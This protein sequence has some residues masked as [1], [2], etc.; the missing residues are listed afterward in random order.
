MNVRNKKTHKP[1]M[2]DKP[3]AAGSVGGQ[4]LWAVAAFL[5]G[6]LLV[7]SLLTPHDATSVFEGAAVPQ[8]LMG[9]ALAVVAPLA[10]ASLGL[11]VPFA[12]RSWLLLA[13]LLAW[14]VIATVLAG[15]GTNPRV[16][17]YGFWQ[18]IALGGGFF[19]AQALL[20][21]PRTRQTTLLILIVGCTAL[22]LQGLYQVAV[23][24]P[25]DRARYLA[26]P[27]GV[28]AEVPNLEAPP[29]SAARKRFEDRLLYSSEPYASFA[30]ANSL[31]VLLS[32][33]I[34]LLMG[35]SMA[36]LAGQPAL[37][38]PPRVPWIHFVPLAIA[39][40]AVLLTWFLTRSRV[41]YPA[42]IV[43]AAYWTLLQGPR[44]REL[45]RLLLWGVGLGSIG[46]LAGSVWLL[47]NDSLVLSEAPKSFSYR[48]EYWLASMAM[49]RDHWLMGIG[50]GNFQ[51]YYPIYKLPAA[52]EII[53]DP[54]NW[55]LDIL[56]SLS[57]P[58][59]VAICLWLA[60]QLWTGGPA[61]PA[62]AA[63][64]TLSSSSQS[65]S[66]SAL[67]QA[68]SQ[69]LLRGAM[70]GGSLCAVALSVLSGLNLWGAIISWF[71]AGLLI[72][73]ARP[74]LQTEPAQLAL[75]ARTA[76]V[77]MLACLL[78]SGSWQ[79]SGL[80]LPMILLLVI[81][82]KHY[83]Q[84]PSQTTATNPLPPTTAT[85]E[86]LVGWRR[87]WPAYLPLVG[88]FIFLIQC[89]RPTIGSWSHIQQA[90]SASSSKQQLALIDAAVQADPLDTEPL[91]M[92][93]QLLTQEAIHA[94]PALFEQMGS[95]AHASVEAWLARDCVKSLN[96]QWSGEHALQLA[97]TAQTLGLENEIYV[98]RAVGYYEQALARYPS[99]IGLR[100]QLAITFA[101][102]DQW[103]E[104]HRELQ[105]ALELD[106]QT[107]HLDKKLESQQ[108]WLPLLPAEAEAELALQKP[109]IPA[110][111]VILWL[112]KSISEHISP[113][114]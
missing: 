32:G 42:L 54:H 37:P 11:R 101:I 72:V 39:G 23:E 94:P 65:N 97:A 76:V 113:E 104:S 19:S 90:Q 88:L 107:P 41:A 102:A 16:A 93:A 68:T 95:Q 56:V 31:A 1:S 26:D 105:I 51:S 109:W 77:T 17:W 108:L 36:R 53:A 89:W 79:A 52:S 100:A 12:R 9:L 28:I 86:T 98:E 33:G 29:G 96:W 13:G 66:A 38:E 80:A 73:W 10:T 87:W 2:P 4:R 46:L 27:E 18:V 35:L 25:A 5:L 21:G 22:A 71:C 70:V 20:L 106:A 75:I 15:N 34:V 74:S 84:S 60:R 99:S 49:L 110:E 6:T 67:D 59:G 91:R 63:E 40:L 45:K 82:R 61:Q 103:P 55:V 69:S 8:N 30:L 43:G 50:L 112:R 47:R 58:L 14:Y 24:F 48:L 83:P 114:H 78:V 92:R 57:V 85:S 64:P 3:A 7:W 62:A 44:L 81:G 111:P